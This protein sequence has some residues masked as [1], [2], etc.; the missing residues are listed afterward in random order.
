MNKGK[1]KTVEEAKA[2][3]LLH[4]DQ[5][6]ANTGVFNATTCPTGEPFGWDMMQ[7]YALEWFMRHPPE[8][9]HISRIYRHECYEWSITQS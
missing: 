2:S 9:W 5:A 7:H 4:I 1:Y 3:L 6:L 8:G